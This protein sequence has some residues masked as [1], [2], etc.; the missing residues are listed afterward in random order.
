MLGK[1]KGNV[2]SREEILEKIWGYKY[3]GETRTV[4]V[5]IRHLRAKIEADGYP[6]F[7]D[8]VRGIGYKL[9]VKGE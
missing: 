4:D 1:N 7:I 8:T 2:V 5:H 6:Q 3:F 9:I